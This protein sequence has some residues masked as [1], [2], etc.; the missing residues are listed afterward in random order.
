MNED[1]DVVPK[2]IERVLV[3]GGCGFIGFHLVNALL[4]SGCVV[5]CIDN[6][7]TG[8]RL[9]ASELRKNS[10]FL[11]IEQD[12]ADAFP[13][14]LYVDE[15]Y[16]MACAASPSQYQRD[17]LHTMRTNVDGAF[18]VCELAKRYGAKVLLASTSEVYG[19]PRMHPQSEEYWGNVNPVGT[20]SCYDEGK[21]AAETI[22][23]DFHRMYGVDI[24]IA[25]IFNTYGPRMALDDGRVVSNF[26]VE[27]LEDRKLSLYGDGLQTRSF[28]YVSDMIAGLL[29]LMGS[30]VQTPVNLGNTEE[31]SVKELACMVSQAV[32]SE[33][34]PE[35]EYCKLPQDDPARRRPDISK[36]VQT[37]QWEPKISLKQ[38]LS[39][40]IS[41][42]LVRLKNSL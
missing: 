34:A 19:D 5:Y 35:F 25:R 23:S 21:R 31:Y 10:R 22:F 39:L 17:P 7:I 6:F 27:A 18:N 12:V 42:F 36:A 2:R 15:I 32:G 11:L 13:N 9:N 40:T 30:N 20:R 41:D 37:L 28:C 33:S 1:S 38:G 8:S 29:G 14:E 26:I 16:H 3:T 4:E 24:R